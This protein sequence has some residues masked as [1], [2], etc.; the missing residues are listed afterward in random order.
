MCKIMQKYI[1][2][3][4]KAEKVED[5]TQG[6]KA[7]DNDDENDTE[8]NGPTPIHSETVIADE[9]KHGESISIANSNMKPSLQLLSSD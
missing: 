3:G 6:Q 4:F 7:E 9:G 1:N 5:F 2:K 8:K